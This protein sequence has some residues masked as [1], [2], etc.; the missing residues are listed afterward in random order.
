M[1]STLDTDE[2][3]DEEITATTELTGAFWTVSESPREKSVLW[4]QY[5]GM[6]Y[7]LDPYCG[8][9]SYNIVT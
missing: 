4:F 2:D 8:L 5:N 3:E 1:P 6:N 7:M 9:S